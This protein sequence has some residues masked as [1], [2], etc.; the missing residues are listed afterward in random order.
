[1]RIQTGLGV[2]VST[3]IVFLLQRLELYDSLGAKKVA[4]GYERHNSRVTD[5]LL[6]PAVSTCHANLS[7]WTNFFE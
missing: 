7:A 5:A 6:L 2:R 1:M 3:L 4:Q